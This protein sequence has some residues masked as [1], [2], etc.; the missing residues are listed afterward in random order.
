MLQPSRRGCGFESPSAG[1]GGLVP[2]KQGP[3]WSAGWCWRL[4]LQHGTCVHACARDRAGDVI[5]GHMRT[6]ENK[7]RSA[8]PFLRALA[9][10][11]H[12][13]RGPLWGSDGFIS[14]PRRGDRPRRVSPGNGCHSRG[15]VRPERGEKRDQ[16]QP[17]TPNFLTERISPPEPA[18]VAPTRVQMGLRRGVHL[19][20]GG[21]PASLRRV[22]HERDRFPTL[23]RSPNLSEC[24]LDP[25][26]RAVTRSKSFRGSAHISG[27]ANC[28]V[29]S[30]LCCLH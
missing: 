23:F 4:Q 16:I 22:C 13:R 6:L 30:E 24:A 2:R 18:L 8:R 5:Q 20:H 12:R 15:S 25:R 29:G 21:V 17:K 19:V 1:A 14:V 26:G 10:L 27:R 11:L 9:P 28:D 3:L 7:Y